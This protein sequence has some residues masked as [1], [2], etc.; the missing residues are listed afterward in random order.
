MGFWTL[1]HQ[2]EFVVAGLQ[3]AQCLHRDE[4]S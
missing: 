2:P 1:N 4:F 3:K